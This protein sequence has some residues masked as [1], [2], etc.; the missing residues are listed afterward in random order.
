MSKGEYYGMFPYGGKA[1][2]C[3]TVPSPDYYGIF[4][5]GGGGL[6][7]DGGA[8]LNVSEELGEQGVG[9][10]M[11]W[12]R[13]WVGVGVAE[14]TEVGPVA[15]RPGPIMGWRREGWSGGASG[16][17]LARALFFFFPPFLPPL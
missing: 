2:C 12:L 17:G 4:Q 6:L 1:A 13:G 7:W 10:I 3:W 9:S 15:E 8:G 5:K 11:G 14:A 16:W